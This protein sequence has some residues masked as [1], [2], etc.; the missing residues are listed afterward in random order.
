MDNYS[1][2]I[3]SHSTIWLVFMATAGDNTALPALSS[4]FDTVQNTLVQAE[5]DAAQVS[6]KRSFADTY[7]AI[8]ATQRGLES[9]KPNINSLVKIAQSR[10]QSLYINS[11]VL[12]GTD[13]HSSFIQVTEA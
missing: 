7:T 10:R 9:Y 13:A 6:L 12:N 8:A 5:E 11:W 4:I 3:I 2:S 1:Y